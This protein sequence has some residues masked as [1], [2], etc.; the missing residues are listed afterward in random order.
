VPPQLQIQLNAESLARTD[1]DPTALIKSVDTLIASARSQQE[2]VRQS[3]NDLSQQ[4]ANTDARQE[5]GTIDATM[6]Q[7]A[8]ELST[9]QAEYRQETFRRDVL[10]QNVEQARD[11]RST[12]SA[13]LS[14]ANVAAEAAGG[15]ALVVSG[16]TA[17]PIQ[18]WPPPLTQSL[19]VATA[20]GLLVGA[21]I[22]LIF[23]G[24]SRQQAASGRPSESAASPPAVATH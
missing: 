15:G 7:L 9:L 10:T 18:A 24:D 12:L 19:P 6:A 2:G 22:T 8:K 16:A 21:G 1:A 23:K 3:I 11:T 20:I 14:E 4:V 17:Q 13:K 5:G